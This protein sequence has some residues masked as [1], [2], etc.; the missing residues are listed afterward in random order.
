MS[1]EGMVED[2]KVV[3]DGPAPFP[4]GTPVR[5]EPVV[6]TTA[7]SVSDAQLPSLYDQLKHVIGKAT[8]LPEDYSVNLDHYLYG[9]P[10]QQP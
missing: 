10:K 1:F 8:G 2:G 4:D 3:F 5:V 9:T 6:P 7:N